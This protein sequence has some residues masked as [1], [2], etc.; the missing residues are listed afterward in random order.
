MTAGSDRRL[1]LVGA[2]HA[3][4][5]LLHT[6]PALVGAGVAVTV[7]DPHDTLY[8]SGM[9]PAVLGGRVAPAAAE[10]PVRRLAESAGARFVRSRAR[11]ID[12]TARVVRTDDGAT[13]PWDVATVAVGSTVPMPDVPAGGGL[14]MGAKP[15]ARLPELRD[16][17]RRRLTAATASPVTVAVVGGGPSAV[18]IAGNLRAAFQTEPRLRI[19]VLSRGHRLLGRMPPAAGAAARWSLEAR[20]ITVETGRDVSAPTTDGDLRI[21][22]TDGA[23]E[24][25]TRR[26][27]VVVLAT[28]LV[29]PPAVGTTGLSVDPAGA[30]RVDDTLRAVGG[31]P[32]FGGGDCVVVGD[33]ELGR[34][35]V[36]AVRQGPILAR[37]VAAALGIRGADPPLRYRPP[38]HPMVIVNPGDGRGILV[39]GDRVRVGRIPLALKLRIDWAFVRSAGRTIRPTLLGP[40]RPTGA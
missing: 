6:L 39:R 5:S 21:A 19:T 28:G 37:N 24:P 1:V 33:R 31:E 17:V 10:I 16:A 12:P 22:A 7:L 2:G 3:H 9:M 29:P 32:V 25:E 36:H 30:L 20:G 40:P 8:Y 13:I 35:G 34:L 26:Y 27:D 18:E 4:L 11:E 38:A 23:G 15:I 14:V